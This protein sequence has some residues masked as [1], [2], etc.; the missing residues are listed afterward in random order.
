[1]NKAEEAER[2]RLIDRIEALEEEVYAL[3]SKLGR[4]F[5]GKVTEVRNEIILTALK[6][7]TDRVLAMPQED[8]REYLSNRYHTYG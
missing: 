5:K 7:E 2:N 3:K 6:E 8:I 1:M 4:C